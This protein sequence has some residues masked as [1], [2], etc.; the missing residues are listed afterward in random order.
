MT[1]P[2]QDADRPKRTCIQLLLCSVHMHN[3]MN[4]RGPHSTVDSLRSLSSEV[5]AR[6]SYCVMTQRCVMRPLRRQAKSL[7]TH[8]VMILCNCS[9]NFQRTEVAFDRQTDRQ[10][11]ISAHLQTRSDSCLAVFCRR[12]KHWATFRVAV[13]DLSTHLPSKTSS[14]D[15]STC[16]TQLLQFM[17]VCRP[18]GTASNPFT[19]RTLPQLP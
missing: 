10:T 14:P 18:A 4:P 8:S 9:G 19:T 5:H 12:T 2:R 11:V 13:H 1:A 15:R 16:D 7:L 6:R 3:G 17:T